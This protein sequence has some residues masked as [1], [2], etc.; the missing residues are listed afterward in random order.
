MTPERPKQDVSQEIKIDLMRAIQSQFYPDSLA[1]KEGAKQ[2]GQDKHFILRRVVLWPAT[3]LDKRGVTLRPE[4]YKKIIL[5]VLDG[6]KKHG[7]TGLIKFW[8]GY[9]AKCVQE[10][11]RHNEESIYEEGKNM[12]SKLDV[13][14]FSA[15]QSVSQSRDPIRALSDAARILDSKR[16]KKP[17]KPSG[18]QL[19]LF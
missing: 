1:T 6:I 18:S 9:L 12:R 10:H 2:W 17:A 8:P 11:F 15:L 19:D 14:M 5:E 7:Q 4:R 13:V 3:W 16:P